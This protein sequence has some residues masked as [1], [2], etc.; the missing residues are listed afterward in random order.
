[1]DKAKR[2]EKI[3]VGILGGSVSEG[4]DVPEK[5]RWHEIVASWF[6]ETFP[7]N[8]V[9]LV[10]GAVPGRGTE[11]FMSC[12]GEHITKDAD[13][14]IIELGINDWHSGSPYDE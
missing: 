10:N 1:M 12:H 9:E 3:T 2:G 8:E 11:Y 4:I 7:A 13:L 14:V 6:N 5:R